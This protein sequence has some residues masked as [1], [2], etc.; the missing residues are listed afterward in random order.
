MNL[1]GRFWGTHVGR[2]LKNGN[3]RRYVVGQGVSN[4]GMWIQVV[5]ELWLILE[6]T[7]SALALGLHQVFRL[8]PVL[9]L[10]LVGGVIGDRV[11]RRRALIITQA[12]HAIA[13]ITLA[14][15]MWV[16][17]PTLTLIY[18]IVLVQGITNAVDNPI[19]RSFIN[20]LVVRDSDIPNSVAL[21]NLVSTIARALGPAIGGVL[22]ATGGVKWCFTVNAASYLAVLASLF[23]INR[24]QLRPRLVVPTGTRAQLLEG[25]RYAFSVPQITRTL[26]VSSVA[27][28]FAWQWNVILPVYAKS[29][30]EGTAQLYG[31]LLF[32]LSI[33]SALGALFTASFGRLGGRFIRWSACGLSLALM[34]SAV[35]S[36]L[37]LVYVSLGLWGGAT[38]AINIAAQARLQLLADS[39]MTS[40]VMSLYSVSFSGAK[41]IGALLIGA[42]VDATNPR[43]TLAVSSLLIG[44]FTLAYAIIRVHETSHRTGD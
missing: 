16:T 4:V 43:V 29:S 24:S 14:L 34:A 41:P 5:A 9:F 33:G 19:R 39:S 40:R 23:M 13:T 12:I 1:D 22:I 31:S 26:L 30:L 21:H 8:G 28:V 7:D 44:G 36:S 17:A 27:A 18:T 37:P 2:S 38:S 10:G 11:E 25:V 6:L 3:Y 32:A 15:A 42:L 35:S 20:D